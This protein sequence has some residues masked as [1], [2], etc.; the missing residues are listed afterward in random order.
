MLPCGDRS[1]SSFLTLR[2]LI[3]SHIA[4][5]VVATAL[6]SAAAQSSDFNRRATATAQILAGITPTAGDPAF[7]RLLGSGAFPEHDKGMAAHGIQARRD[8][9]GVV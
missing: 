8:R 6:G 5:L 1:S 3:G 2:Y 9:K 7:V 4:A